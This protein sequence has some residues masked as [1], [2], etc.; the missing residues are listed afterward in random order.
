[1][2][3]RAYRDADAAWAAVARVRIAI[4]HLKTARLLLQ[5][6]GSRRARRAATRAIKSAEGAER[7]SERIYTARYYDQRRKEGTA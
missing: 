6:A 7:H 1:M 4:D 5:E 2:K 3:L